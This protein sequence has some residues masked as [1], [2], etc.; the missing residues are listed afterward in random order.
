MA[1]DYRPP[2][3]P[4]TLSPRELEVWR[5]VADG[6]SDKQIAMRLGVSYNTERVYVVSLA[7]KFDI[8]NQGATRAILTRL[9]HERQS[10]TTPNEAA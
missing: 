8:Q 1:D 2:G 6:L 9:W 3:K 5:L 4:R 10:T 7:F